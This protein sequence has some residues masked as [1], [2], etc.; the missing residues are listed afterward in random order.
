LNDTL[1][2]EELLA[3]WHSQPFAVLAHVPLAV[4]FFFMRFVRIHQN[5]GGDEEDSRG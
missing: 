5:G 4:L 2:F 1:H 3:A